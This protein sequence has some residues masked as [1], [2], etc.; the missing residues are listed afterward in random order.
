MLCGSIVTL[1]CGGARLGERF[2]GAAVC[3]TMVGILYTAESTML[4]FSNGITVGAVTANLLW[5]IFL[6]SIFSFLGAVITELK[7]GDPDLKQV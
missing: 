5:R 1:G 7:L 6:F 4:V 2:F 3:G